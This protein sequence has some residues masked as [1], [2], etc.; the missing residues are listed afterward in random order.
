MSILP[1]K[2]T[3]TT[4]IVETDRLTVYAQARLTA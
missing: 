1:R 3:A 4:S 2:Q